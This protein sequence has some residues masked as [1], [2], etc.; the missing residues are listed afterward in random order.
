MYDGGVSGGTSR[1]HFWRFCGASG[2]ATG[3]VVPLDTLGEGRDLEG[4]EGGADAAAGAEACG[5]GCAAA[6]MPVLFNPVDSADLDEFDAELGAARANGQLAPR[7]HASAGPSG[8][9][10]QRG[11]FVSPSPSSSGMLLVPSMVSTGAANGAAGSAAAAAGAMGG[12]RSTRD[13]A[14]EAALPL[15]GASDEDI[16]AALSSEMA[17]LQTSSRVAHLQRPSESSAAGPSLYDS[18]SELSLMRTPD[19]QAPVAAHVAALQAGWQQP[20]AAAAG[21]ANILAAPAPRRLLWQ[22]QHY[23]V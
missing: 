20:N 10:S 2:K 7:A 6:A 5:E 12:A 16:A 18:P 11:S 3:A 22:Q 8:G 23:K 14:T 4:V 21:A 19:E 13:A 1:R 17:V 15:E 9:A